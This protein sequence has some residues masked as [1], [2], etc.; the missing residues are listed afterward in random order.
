MAKCT[1]SLEL[2]RKLE[3]FEHVLRTTCDTKVIVP[4]QLW[5]SIV[6]FD[7]AFHEAHIS[8]A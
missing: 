3:E 2:R 7:S 5:D 4:G 6:G 1:I 8:Y